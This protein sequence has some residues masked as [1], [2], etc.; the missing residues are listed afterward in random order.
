M[1][2]LS[3][4]SCC[5]VILAAAVLFW[6]PGKTHGQTS[7]AQLK[8]A[9]SISGKVTVGGK[10]AF[11]ITIGA[12][13]SDSYPNQASAHTAAT[14][15][16]GRYRLFGLAPGTYHVTALTPS[17]VAAE[18]ISSPYG[19]GKMVL[20]SAAE[21]AEDV[22][23][24]LA[25]GAVITGRITDEE[26]KPVIEERMNLE[27][28]SPAGSEALQITSFSMDTS[29]YQT[30]DRGSYRIYGLS[31]GRYKISAGTEAGAFS[32]TGGR[33]HFT[34]TFY[35]DTNDTAK[36]TIIELSEG[37]E[38]S[39]IDIRLGHR[40]STFSVAGRVVDSEK[41]EPIGGLRPGY[42]RVS[43]TNA[44][45]GIFIYGQPTNPQ[46]QFR[47]DGL[48]PGHYTIYVSSRFDGGD[49]Y[50]EPIVFDVVDRDVTNLELKA[51]RGLTLSG[52]VVPDSESARNASSQLSGLR[53]T[54]SVRTDTHTPNNNSAAIVAADGSFSIKGMAPG[55]AFLYLF[56]P[57]SPNSRRF[58]LIRVESDGV[59]QTQG[60]DLQAGLSVT[61]LR[62]FVSYGTD[63][64]RGAV[65]F[66]NGNPPTDARISVGIHRNEGPV[67]RGT[68][69]DTRGRFMITEIPPGNYE[70]T[71]NIGFYSPTVQ[72]P[73]RPRPPLKQ[74]VTVVNDAEV[75][76][77]F[78][79]PKEGG[80]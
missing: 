53:I 65:K 11:G 40:S 69:V 48:E 9:G 41:G 73:P 8:G 70:V 23:F 12:V 36:A 63:G 50:S 46:G 38:A 20:L 19:S 66:E 62:V 54:A 15:N 71:L 14:D 68:T 67:D 10:A 27:L 29:M 33:G 16:E 25:R 13:G 30:D 74:L 42:G 80:P 17:L 34:Q 47:F 57:N 56:S 58:S 77:N 7:E 4:L 49:L 32:G 26:G 6:I 75:E 1:T 55:K 18:T 79:V 31:A 59:D 5:A 64:I 43:P 37:I 39:N 3:R 22:D 61:N 52:V 45:S 24:K 51:L 78:T 21:A 44:G 72:P 28:V 60:I 2:R 35:G 76:V